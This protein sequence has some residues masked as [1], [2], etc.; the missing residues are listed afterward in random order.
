MKKYKEKV[1]QDNDQYRQEIY[2]E[3]FIHSMV[4]RYSS[5]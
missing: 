5:M 2:T 3:K 4:V 1:A